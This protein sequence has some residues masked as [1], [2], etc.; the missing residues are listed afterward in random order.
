[1][2]VRVSSQGLKSLAE[3]LSHSD[4]FSRDSRPAGTSSGLACSPEVSH[5]FGRDHVVSCLPFRVCTGVVQPLTPIRAI[6][7]RPSLFPASFTRCPVKSP[8]GGFTSL[9]EEDNGLTPFRTST[10][11]AT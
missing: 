5:H 7:A 3:P 8:R 11:I 6:T 1:V 4:K 9:I 2:G 10:K